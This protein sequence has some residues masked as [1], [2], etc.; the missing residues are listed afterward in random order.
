MDIGRAFTFIT[1]DD[2]WITKVGIGAILS[3][4]SFLILPVFLLG[5]YLVGVTRNV[6][7]GLPQPL[8]RWTNWEK[9]FM[10]GL[11]V[12]IAQLIYTLP[13]W[14]LVCIA[15]VVS[16]GIGGVGDQ[17]V[18]AAGISAVVLV[19]VCLALLFLIALFFISPAIVIQ[20]V[21]TD[22]FGATLRF[23]EVLG[24]AR[25]HMGKILMA[26]LAALVA[27][28]VLSAVVGALN[29]IPC[30]GQIVGLVIGIVAGPW[31][32]MSIGHLYGQIA[33]NVDMTKPPKPAF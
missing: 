31:L 22:E 16:V 11:Y 32:S 33:A 6:K 13:F 26:A 14:L 23:G 15:G 8:P 29:V 4:L 10:D 20:Y 5:G 30:L 9:L 24:I 18:A 17:D 21:R 3:L 12:A 7:D 19:T 2:E 28:L 25:D 27:S 1:E